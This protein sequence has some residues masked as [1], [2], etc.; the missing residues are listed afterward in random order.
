MLLRNVIGEVDANV[1]VQITAFSTKLKIDSKEIVKNYFVPDNEL[2]CKGRMDWT[3]LDPEYSSMDKGIRLD[4]GLDGDRYE[5]V[6][7]SFMA[8]VVSFC[9]ITNSC[10][11]DG[12]AEFSIG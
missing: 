8:R 2:L 11:C 10:L 6:Y 5:T 3:G 4:N 12:P 1:V 7:R 9:L